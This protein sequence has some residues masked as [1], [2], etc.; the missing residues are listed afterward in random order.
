MSVRPINPGGFNI[1]DITEGIDYG[2]EI[3][4]NEAAIEFRKTYHN[5]DNQPEWIKKGPKNDNTS[6]VIEY[7]TE[8]NPYVWVDGGTEPHEIMGNP[9]LHF[10]TNSV[11]KTTPGKLMSG[12]GSFGNTWRHATIVQNPGIEA[13]DFSGQVF[14]VIDPKLES[15]IQFGIDKYSFTY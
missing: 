2:L 6:R 7:Y 9:L 5:W 1:K 14:E 13:R 12:Q 8:S 15:Y 10:T 11:P 4:A 3:A